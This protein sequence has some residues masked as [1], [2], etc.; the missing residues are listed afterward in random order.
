MSEQ[1]IKWIVLQEYL[2]FNRL[3]ANPGVMSLNPSQAT[4]MEIDNETVSV[5]ILPFH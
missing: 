3:T 4:F 5:A 1:K 2:T